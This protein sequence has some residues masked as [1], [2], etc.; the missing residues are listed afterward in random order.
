MIEN[1]YCTKP[2]C[3]LDLKPLQNERYY[4]GLFKAHDKGRSDLSIYQ[5][6]IHVRCLVQG[7]L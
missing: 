4:F 6:C 3:V 7:A 2:A 5:S 1:G